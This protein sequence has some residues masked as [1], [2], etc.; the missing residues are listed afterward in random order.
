[1]YKVVVKPQWFLHT[2]QRLQPLPKLLLLLS[3]IE[4]K[5]SLAAAARELGMSYRRAWGSLH[6]FGKMFG[7]P[8]VQFRHGRGT[9]LSAFGRKLLWADKR[10]S[11]RLAPLL[12][13]LASELEAEM[14][15]EAVVSVPML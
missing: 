2:D 6:E 4:D 13:N 15:V 8:V 10:I 7:R 11:A 1:M 12:Q 5:G 14:Q 3:A 9:E